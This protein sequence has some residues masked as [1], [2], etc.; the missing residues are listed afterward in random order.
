LAEAAGLLLP[1]GVDT[2]ALP[3]ALPAAGAE[4]GLATAFDAAESMAFGLETP[5]SGDFLAGI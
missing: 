2:A 5:E 3:V 4:V 1:S